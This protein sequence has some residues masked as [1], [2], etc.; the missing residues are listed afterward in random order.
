MDKMEETKKKINK[1][2]NSIKLLE[3]KL[4]SMKRSLLE[5]NDEICPICLDNFNNPSVLDCCGN[6]F[7]FEC[8]AI[9][10]NGSKCPVCQKIINTTSIHVIRDEKSLNAKKKMINEEEKK[11]KFDC[12]M[13]IIKKKK[14]NKILIFADY[15]DTFKKIEKFMISKKYNYGILDSSEKSTKT[16]KE[17]VSGNLNILMLTAKNFGAGC[18]FQCTTDIVIFHRFKKQMEE[19]IIGRGQRLGRKGTLNVYYLIHDNESDSF[20]DNMEDINCNYQEYLER[21]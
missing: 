12:L 8:L 6:M 18:N 20:E 14:N 5:L 1:I 15:H 16:I 13:D 11:D 21:I 2:E 7:C 9:A 4:S 3:N 10:G 19:Q 17:F